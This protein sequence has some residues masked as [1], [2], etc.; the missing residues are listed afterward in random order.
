MIREEFLTFDDRDAVS[1][2]HHDGMKT[3]NTEG[4]QRAGFKEETEHGEHRVASLIH[5]FAAVCTGIS[6]N[7]AQKS[8][9]SQQHRQRLMIVSA[10]LCRHIL[11]TPL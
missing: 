1:V 6:S 9:K 7:P 2:C 3:F 4:A 11:Q 8:V 5:T 10:L